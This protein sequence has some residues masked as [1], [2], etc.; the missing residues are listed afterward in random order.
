VSLGLT[1]ILKRF[2]IVFAIDLRAL[3]IFRIA[4]GFLL[5]ADLA[6]R[7]P[8]WNL[9]YTED[10]AWPIAASRNEGMAP[11][12]G[13]SLHWLNSSREWS[14]ALAAGQGVAGLALIVGY[15]TRIATI[16][17]WLFLF[18]LQ[19]RNQLVN[20]GGDIELR[21]LLFWSIWLPLG[22]FWS[23]DTVRAA[24]SDATF[25]ASP[26]SAAL[27]LQVSIIYITSAL[28]KTDPVWWKT[29]E[30]IHEA[31]GL[32]SYATPL[33]LWFREFPQ[34]LRPATFATL[35]LEAFGPIAAICAWRRPNL[36]LLLALTFICFHVVLA[37][38][39]RLGTF[40]YIGMAGWLPFI[41]GAA[42]DRWRLGASDSPRAL[43]PAPRWQYL[44]VPVAVTLA[45][46]TALRPWF[47][48]IVPKPALAVARAL[49]L[50]Q[51]WDLFAPRPMQ[52]DGWIVVVGFFG[53]GNEVDLLSGRTPDWNPPRPL[54][55]HLRDDRWR[56]FLAQV[57]L[58]GG[59]NRL[60]PFSEW[61]R[62]E[63]DRAHPN[64]P[65]LEQVSIYAVLLSVH[66]PTQPKSRELYVWPESL[67]EAPSSPAVS[68]EATPNL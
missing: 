56:R 34:L 6:N 47:R 7:A 39:L 32:E 1:R 40:P 49:G 5:L 41:P 38:T 28:L 43:A 31:L 29:G 26:A 14:I 21:L 36:R 24:P 25:V 55:R 4:L 27:L 35:V 22:S 8:D 67:K 10:G 2:L 60:L 3:A 66:E 19:T 45:F 13:W 20:H 18:S 51:R 33:A 62:R 46:L 12:A 50:A 37:F 59:S 54:H 11:S 68:P 53:G 58:P 23:C 17:G 30:A 16:V 15:R 64:H 48:S 42:F 63:F 57:R 65:P 61:A 52:N 9:L 44:V